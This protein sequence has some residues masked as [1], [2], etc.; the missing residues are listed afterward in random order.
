MLDCGHEPYSVH[1]EVGT[2]DLPAVAL[3]LNGYRAAIRSAYAL[4]P[5]SDVRLRID[6]AGGEVTSLPGRVQAVAP[7][8]AR[9]HLAHL[10]VTG[11]EGAWAPFLALVGPT[12]ALS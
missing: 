1:V 12:A 6:W 2:A 8:G 9:E 4:E 7:W 3:E 10:E 11:I 5:E